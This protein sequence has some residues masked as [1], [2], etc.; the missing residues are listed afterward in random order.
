VRYGKASAR[1]QCRR[2]G[3]PSIEDSCRLR[4]LRVKYATKRMFRDTLYRQI[5]RGLRELKDGDTFESCAND[6]LRQIYPSLASREG[7]DDAGLDGLIANE[8]KSSIQ[9]I[10]TT[11]LDVLGNLSGSIQANIKKRGKSHACI[12][13]TS[14]RL[15]N[16]KKRALEDRAKELGRPLVQIYDQAEMAQLLYRDPRWL[17]EL[18]GLSGNPPPLSTLPV[19]TRPLFDVPPIGRD[20][21]LAKIMN[22]SADLV[23]VGQPG[24]GKTHLLFIAAKKAKGRFVVDEDITQVAN[25]VRSI[26]PRFV[27]IDDAHSRLEF[28]SRLK[29]L[30]QQIDANFRV[31]ASCWPGQE[32]EVCKALQ[33][34]KKNCH[35][36]EG[37][38]QKQIKEVI[39]SQKIFGPDHLVA[40]IIHQSQGKPGL[41]VT[42]CRLC[43]ESGTA[44][45]VVLGTALA[46]D[47]RH[48]FEP[49]L[50]QAATHLLACF[51]I[52]GNVGMTLESVARLLGKNTFEV[53]RTV[54]QLSAAGVLDVSPESR[55]SVHPLRLRQALVRDEFFT[56]P[57]VDLA[58]YLSEVP[59]LAATA[60]VLIEAKL[61]GGV[62]SDETMRQLLR[63]LGATDERAAFERYAR[64]GK[65][66]SDWVLDNYPEKLKGVAEVVLQTSPEKA[67][68]M[69]LNSAAAVRNQ[70]LSQGWSARDDD[71]LPEIK[72]WILSARSNDEVSQ[73]RELLATAL[74]EWRKTNN[75]TF[76]AIVATELVLSIKH[77][78]TSSPPGEPMTMTLHFGVV[79]QNQVARIASLWPKVLSILVEADPSQQGGVAN[80]FH[81]WIHPDFHGKNTRKEYEVESRNFAKQMMK[82]LLA[83][84]VGNWTMHHHLHVYAEK[85]DLLS[86][87]KIDPIAAILYPPGDYSDWENEERRRQQSAD[88]LASQLIDKDPT[89]VAD[90]LTTIEEQARAASISFP[91]WGRHVCWRIAAA[92]DRP[93]VWIK[94]LV[95]RGAPAFLI[96][97]FL[98]K[99][100]TRDL[101]VG[102]IWV[103][104]ALE[105]PSLQ[106]LGVEVVLKHYEFEQ[107]I[108]QKASPLFKNC[109]GMIE[110]CILRHEVGTKN[111][112]ALL[113]H[114]NPDV[115][116]IVAACMWGIKA[117]ARIADELLEDWKRAIV[118]QVDERQEH[119]LE[120]IFPKHPDIAFEWI[121]WRLDGIR[122]GTRPFWFGVRYDRALSA[123]VSA[124]TR[125]QKRE[126][127][128]KAPR[129]SSVAE[130]VRSLVGR[131]MELF[132]Y[133]LSREELEG[134]RLD[135]L[136]LDFGSGLHAENVVHDFDEVWQQMAIAAMEKGFSEEDIFSATQ[137]GSYCGS[138]PMSSMY[139]AKMAPFEKLLKNENPRLQRIGQIGVNTFSS[140]RDSHLAHE[141]RAAV[142]GELA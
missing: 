135:P 44:R 116:G 65:S 69:L 55:I 82:E 70:R 72:R 112:K 67:L 96:E 52:G 79:A 141:K 14:Q 41:A 93:G 118:Q 122:D 63:E 130:L 34:S 33:I 91:S 87:I 76:I 108:W 132:L 48:S 47:V 38:A 77:E 60:R 15:T 128:H 100:A 30:K 86:E 84:T 78:D 6:L 58:P 61:M 119:I 134:V 64:L 11:G 17:K 124:L 129:S 23:V 133:L 102:E 92:T 104:L 89:R 53:K 66:E 136:R 16:S 81:E 26:Q 54:E 35:A 56:P 3:Q 27:I 20:D 19:T 114:E 68:A 111:L 142:R 90:V 131:D 83:A 88:V 127:I 138:G 22:S 31:V 9:L 39:Q 94:A 74:T 85:L 98:M 42:L 75:D 103:A 10:C 106:M 97:F 113:N 140:P 51:S 121:A 50:G 62:L 101:T 28:L 49:L 95:D 7:G 105:T 123:A 99:I 117:E 32:E 109:R 21:D 29:L 59:D 137:S 25:G 126:L 1:F 139:A 73:R 5:R 24:A 110:G 2:G 40:E 8:D 80:I 115:S 36:L 57:V 18:L 125:E 45:D 43:W 13:A 46:S 107:P 120:K 4:A 12:F 37:L 71:I